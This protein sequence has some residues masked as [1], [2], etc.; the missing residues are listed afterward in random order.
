V[1]QELNSFANDQSWYAVFDPTESNGCGVQKWRKPVD[2]GV[3]ITGLH[4][5]EKRIEATLFLTCWG[6][7]QLSVFRQVVRLDP[8]GANRNNLL[9]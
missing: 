7:Q 1:L 3:R 6:K 5:P 9:Q 2:R 8:E 4:V